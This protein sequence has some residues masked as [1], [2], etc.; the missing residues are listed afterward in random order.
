M[1][2]SLLEDSLYIVYMIAFFLW[3]FS[4]FVEKKEKAV[5]EAT[6]KPQFSTE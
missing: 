1:M 5:S 6:D 2:P 4:P 3:F